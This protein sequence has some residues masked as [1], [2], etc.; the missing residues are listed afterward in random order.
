MQTAIEIRAVTQSIQLLGL[1]NNVLDLAILCFAG[2]L[3]C[4]VDRQAVFTQTVHRLVLAL[5]VVLQL[6][7]TVG[8][9]DTL[10][11]SQTHLGNRVGGGDLQAFIFVGKASNGGQTQL[12]IGSQTGNAYQRASV[13]DV[14]NAF[15]LRQQQIEQQGLGGITHFSLVVGTQLIEC[16]LIGNTLN[17]EL[18]Q[19]GLRLLL[20]KRQELLGGIQVGNRFTTDVGVFMLP[21]GFQKILKKGHR[22]DPF[23]LS[24]GK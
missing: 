15:A 21:F 9:M 23:K 3:F 11:C 4:L 8:V 22:A 24:L 1:L 18:A 20:D 17:R 2:F 7:Q 6:V 13:T 16:L 14:I 19:F 5:S 12:M 10:G